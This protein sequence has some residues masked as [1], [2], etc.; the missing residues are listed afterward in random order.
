MPTSEGPKPLYSARQPS[1][2]AIRLTVRYIL[3]S[4]RKSST[5]LM[6]YIVSTN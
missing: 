6:R 2:T 3:Q 1:S 5:D 4:W